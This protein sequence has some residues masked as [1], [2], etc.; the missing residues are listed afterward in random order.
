MDF[1]LTK[2]PRSKKFGE[3]WEIYESSFPANERRDIALQASAMKNKSYKF[4]SVSENKETIA[5]I[6][7]WEFPSF[8]FLDHFA[9][10]KASRNKGI[11]SKILGKFLD[12]NAKKT[13][14]LEVE[15]PESETAAR[16]IGFYENFGFRLN[17][18]S[19]IQPSF[20]KEKNPVPMLLMSCPK[21]LG[22]QEFHSVRATIHKSAYGRK[23][24]LIRLKEN[25]R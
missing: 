14:I 10:K 20:G 16:R 8:I 15:R 7:F 17:N 22:S 11:G 2:N 25:Q 1:T 6:A 24:P 18:F 5:L 21:K 23:K 9:V 12:K 19:Y 4:Y 3:T 13:I